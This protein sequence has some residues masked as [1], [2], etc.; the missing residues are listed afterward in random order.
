MTNKP[1]DPEAIN[2]YEMR[3]SKQ[4]NGYLRKNSRRRNIEVGF[5]KPLLDQIVAEAVK[6]GWSVCR[7]IRHLCEASIEGIE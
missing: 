5:P 1:P 7:M 4:A 6:R 3:H 2:D